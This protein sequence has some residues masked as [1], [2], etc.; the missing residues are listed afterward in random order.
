MKSV[1]NQSELTFGTL[2]ILLS[3]QN[4]RIGSITLVGGQVEFAKQCAEG[5]HGK[6][7]GSPSSYS[8]I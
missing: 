4:L 5:R 8:F 6:N 7:E 2:L 3:F 1:D